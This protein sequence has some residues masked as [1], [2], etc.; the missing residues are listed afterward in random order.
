MS[1]RI[2]EAEP[3]VLGIGLDR[4]FPLGFGTLDK[5]P[6]VLYVLRAS[7]GKH[8]L[9]GV[10]SCGRMREITSLSLGTVLP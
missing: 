3:L 5:L 9:Q 1:Y 8:H 6:R 2:V 7:D 4:P 10:S